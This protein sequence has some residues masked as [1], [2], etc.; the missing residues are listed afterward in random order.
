MVGVVVLF[1]ALEPKKYTVGDYDV[2]ANSQHR[3]EVYASGTSA[4][5]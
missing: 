1:T 5:M 2:L 3:G 4:A